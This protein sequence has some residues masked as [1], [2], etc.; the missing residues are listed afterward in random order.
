MAVKEIIDFIL[1]NGEGRYDNY[2]KKQLAEF[3]ELHQKYGT[4]M[5]VKDK[6]GILAVARWNWVG[7]EAVHIMDVVIRKDARGVEALKGLL[8]LGIKHNPTCKY[9][10]YQRGNIGDYA[11]RLYKVEDFLGIRKVQQEASL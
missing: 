2:D 5:T 8:I 7:E 11:V 6:K 4:L 9:I 1:T 3:I 10:G